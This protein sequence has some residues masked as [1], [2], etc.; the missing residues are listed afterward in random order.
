M[1]NPRHV[2]DGVSAALAALFARAL[3]L[4][5]A[6]TGSWAGRSESALTRFTATE[7]ASSSALLVAVVAALCWASIDPAGYTGVWDTRLS[8]ELGTSALSLNLSEWISSGLM[9]VFFFVVGL[10]AR[11][12]FDIGELR[13]RRRVITPLLA[14]IGGM[15]T[16]VVLFMLITSGDPGWRGWGVAMSTDTAFALGTLAL[17]GPRFP[18]RLR[19]FLLA[20]VVID[21]IVAL[22]VIATV[23]TERV[24]PLPLVVALLLFALIV[25]TSQLRLRYGWLS[26]VLA[27]AAWVA[28]SQSGIDPLLIGLAM[29]LYAYAAPAART[30]LERATTLFR[31]FREQPTPELARAASAALTTAVSPNERLQERFQRWS[32]FFIVPLFAL[33]NTGIPISGRLLASAFASPLTRAIVIGYV[34]GKPVGVVAVSWLLDRLSG[35]RLRPPVGWLAVGGGGTLAGIAFTV[36][37]LVA[38]RAF[39][40]EQLDHAKVGIL[41][42]AL[43]SAAT[44]WAVFAVARRLPRRRRARLLLGTSEMITDLAIPVDPARDHVRGSLD[45]PVTLVEYGDFECPYCGQAEPIVRELLDDVELRYVWRHLPLV[46]VHP[47]ARLA[48]LASEAASRQ[49]AFW[50]MHDQL[51]AHQGQLLVTDLHRY[52]DLLGLD[53]D[54][55]HQDLSNREGEDHIAQDVDSAELSGAAGTPTFFINGARHRGAYDRDTLTSQ[56]RLAHIRASIGQPPPGSGSAEL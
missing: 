3:N 4:A 30:D 7:T 13:E 14:G 42:A 17:V 27:A 56:I 12:E 21:D 23:Y 8:I 19:S 39:E 48:A 15:V 28:L 33:S 16:A 5:T 50:G 24:S 22:V 54:R 32:S 29:G 9:T 44:S 55:F 6:G 40:G 35:G 52:A 38:T 31:G 49:G 47:H 34:V 43:L 46:D 18:E 25:A 1:P 37:L 41:A 10:E 45:A 36:S 11:R 53:L 26:F 20:V 2:V 51:L